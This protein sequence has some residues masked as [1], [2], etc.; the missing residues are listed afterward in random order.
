MSEQLR[1]SLQEAVTI[2]VKDEVCRTP[3]PEQSLKDA[4]L[5]VAP[6]ASGQVQDLV[7]H[8]VQDY[9]QA[10]LPTV[11]ANGRCKQSVPTVS[12]NIQ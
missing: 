7:L 4:A 5:S 8:S 9:S 3:Q 1:Q 10:A 12:A 11:S 2:I 6:V